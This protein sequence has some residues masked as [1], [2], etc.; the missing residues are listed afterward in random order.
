M[1]LFFIV[2]FYSFNLLFLYNLLDADLLGSLLIQN[3]NILFLLI[4]VLLNILY[5]LFKDI[6]VT[7]Y[8][9]IQALVECDAGLMDADLR[10]GE[11]LFLL[12]VG[13]GVCLFLWDFVGLL[14]LVCDWLVVVFCALECL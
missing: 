3:I 4:L 10:G 12:A 2:I 8:L 7:A 14:L 5:Q 13:V 1:F 11:L 6:G 9:F